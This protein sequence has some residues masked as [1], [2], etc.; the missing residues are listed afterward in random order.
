[1][2]PSIH[3]RYDL[4]HLPQ[5]VC[6]FSRAAGA[7][8]SPALSTDRVPCAVVPMWGLHRAFHHSRD[9]GAG[10]PHRPRTLEVSASLPRGSLH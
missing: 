9:N 4:F 3:L 10:A 1:M 2:E 8:L 6:K 5:S 7:G